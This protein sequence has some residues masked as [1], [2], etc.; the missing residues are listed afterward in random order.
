M[1]PR[2]VCAEDDALLTRAEQVNV[3][4]SRFGA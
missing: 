2:H 4:A 3:N 1:L